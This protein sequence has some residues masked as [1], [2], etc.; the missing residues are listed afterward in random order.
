[1][2]RVWLFDFETLTWSARKCSNGRTDWI[3]GHA[4]KRGPCMYALGMH[5]KEDQPGPC[6]VSPATGPAVEDGGILSLQACQ[7]LYVGS[8]H[9]EQR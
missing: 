9:T 2:E 1:M 3:F 6:Q 8:G 4:I 5:G 7:A